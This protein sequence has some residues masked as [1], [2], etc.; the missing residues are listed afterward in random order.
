MQVFS[1]IRRHSSSLLPKH[2]LIETVGFLILGFGL[3]LALATFSYSPSDY[4]GRSTT[5]WET[6]NLAGPVGAYIGQLLLGSFGYIG[7]VW[8]PV[9]LGWG[10]LISFGFKVLPSIKRLL[11]LI[12]ALCC[13]AAIME[14]QGAYLSWPK[15]VF[16]YGGSVGSML[17]VPA[18]KHFGYGGSLVG[19]VILS[20]IILS[21]TQNITP[22]ATRYRL[23]EGA[24]KSKKAIK[25]ARSRLLE[26]KQ[27]ED[28]RLNGGQTM[29]GRVADNISPGS[30]LGGGS[31][32]I[33]SR[34]SSSDRDPSERKS[35]RGKRKATPV[36]TKSDGE[37]SSANT[38]D[39]FKDEI[40][41]YYAHAGNVSI[42][43][44]SFSSSEKPSKKS[45]VSHDTQAKR[46]TNQLQEFKVAG[47]VVGIHEGPVVTTYEFEPSA[48]QKVSKI[49]SLN[50]DLARLLEAKSLR[51]LSPIPGKKTIGFEVP[52][53]K[54]RMVGFRDLVENKRFNAREVQLPVGMGVDTSGQPVVADLA[55]MPHLL[56]AGSTG[57]GKSVFMNSLICSLICRH[58][59]R[60]LRFVMIDPKM[61]ELAPFNSLPHMACPVVTD[62][63][64]DAKKKL[65]ALVA[66]MERRYKLFQSVGARNIQG[67]NDIIKENRKSEY[68]RFE[69]RWVQLPYVVLVI[70][71]LAD[72]MMVLGKDAETPITRLAQKARA[73]GVHVV[74]ATQRPSADVVTG[75]LKSNFPTRIAFRVS[76]SIDS[77]TI[78]DQSGAEYLLGKGDMIYM[79]SGGTTRLHGAYLSDQEVTKLVNKWK[80]T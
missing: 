2:S 29:S 48:G 37:R 14:V 1:E 23:E 45:G 59:P 65:D 47:N 61:V 27:S 78:L 58:S 69:D 79:S 63:Q 33:D 21:L 52:N 28:R 54:S 13:L 24:Y 42:S 64:E 7:L 17:A 41:I 20:F 60:K 5:L 10:A 49:T 72:L 75:L 9:F 43:L 74:I 70:D 71:E 11:G 15:P 38:Q 57:S 39:D 31:A 6:K 25:R 77:R 16:G 36:D 68:P 35:S 32:A 53:A 12:G 22:S 18:V 67:F 55:A 76:S 40:K 30:A 51:I 62:P 4:V 34:G 73:A 19:F 8:S 56:V 26:F 80:K 66:E 3:F 46:L 50:E 44:T